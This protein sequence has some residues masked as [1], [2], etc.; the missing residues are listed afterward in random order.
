MS[1]VS[2]TSTRHSSIV[3]S[4]RFVYL[5]GPQTERGPMEVFKSGASVPQP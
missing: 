4:A 1:M 5:A 3:G 2:V